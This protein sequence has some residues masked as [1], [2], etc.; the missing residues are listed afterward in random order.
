VNEPTETDYPGRQPLSTNH[1]ELQK[2][3]SIPRLCYAASHIAVNDS[4]LKVDHSVTSPGTPEALMEHIDW[5]STRRLRRRLLDQGFGIAEAMDTAQRF[6]IGWPIAKRLIEETSNLIDGR[7]FTAGASYDNIDSRIRRTVIVDAI[8]EQSKF[9]QSVGGMP[10]IL[11]V[12]WLC[13]TNATPS[14]YI[15]FYTDILRELDGPVILH[16]LGPSF[17]S[18][19][20]GYFP[21]NTAIQI[22]RL[23][24]EKLRG[25]KVSLLNPEMEIQLRNELLESA[26]VVFTGDDFNFPE[27]IWGNGPGQSDSTR[28]GEF[29]IRIGRFSHALLG[30][31]DIVAEPVSRAMSHLV[32]NDRAQYNAIM[33]S[34][35]RLSRHIFSTPTK[36]YKSG[37]A[38]V[39]GIANWQPNPMLLNHEEHERPK[40]YYRECARLAV[41]AGLVEEQAA[42]TKLAQFEPFLPST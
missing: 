37:L 40:S 30:I 38:F 12:P 42:K 8:V 24:P 11:P 5:R 22:L 20:Q 27:L 19:L 41:D 36:F 23:H 34:C 25:I 32:Q 21:D 3:S 16:W 7:P 6:S 9:I 13:E 10:V 14:K 29:S 33:G 17:A 4:Y 35:E 1:I 39:S 26:Q 28:V 2:R 18:N 15:D 31:L